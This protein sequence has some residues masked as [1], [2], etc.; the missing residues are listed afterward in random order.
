MNKSFN[1]TFDLQCP[2]RLTVSVLTF[3]IIITGIFGNALVIHF[4]RFDIKRRKT[5]DRVLLLQMSIINLLACLISLPLHYVDIVHMGHISLSLNTCSTLCFIKLFTLCL[6]LGVSYGTLALLCYERYEAITK[7]P[8]QRI[9]NFNEAVLAA[10]AVLAVVFV[11]T[12]LT[13]C[14]Y[15]VDIQHGKTVCESLYEITGS[16]DSERNF[17]TNIALIVLNTIFIVISNCLCFTWLFYTDLK[18]RNH[19][20]SV[21][22]TLGDQSVV[23]ET[24]MVRSALAFAVMYSIVWIPFG[25]ARA[26]RNAIPDS[27]SISCFYLTTFTISYSSF[28]IVSYIYLFFDKRVKDLFV[29]QFARLRA[30]VSVENTTNAGTSTTGN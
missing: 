17:Y 30:K 10:L 26:L 8:Q 25:I 20:E 14:G 16:V 12:L 3:V 1:T 23:K 29:K 19:I 28:S 13:M 21:R 5:P 22:S 24:R 9:L 11:S 15:I 2:G 18:I 27:P 6:C 4:V 7:F